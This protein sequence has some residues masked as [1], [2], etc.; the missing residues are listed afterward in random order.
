MYDWKWLVPKR[1]D[2]WCCRECLRASVSWILLQAFFGVI[3]CIRWTMCR[4]PLVLL[5]LL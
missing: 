1:V 3:A 5:L 4:V 2:G